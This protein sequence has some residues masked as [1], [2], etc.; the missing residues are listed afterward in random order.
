MG[1]K[2]FGE[3]N[4]ELKGAKG[5]WRKGRPRINYGRVKRGQGRRK[6]T[7]KGKKGES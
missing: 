7:L 5:P 3:K 4:R 1:A 6:E 2:L